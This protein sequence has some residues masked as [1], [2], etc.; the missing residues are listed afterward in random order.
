MSLQTAA[1]RIIG[2]HLG[3]PASVASFQAQASAA[4]RLAG[5]RR[6]A[7]ELRRR[8]QRPKAIV[9]RRPWPAANAR[10]RTLPGRPS[11]P[12]PD[13]YW[14]RNLMYTQAFLLNCVYLEIL[15]RA[16]TRS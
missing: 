3:Y 12:N 5:S 7:A 6:P 11:K 14:L 9:S 1:H 8:E 13:L 15:F 2:S 4:A 16:V 10:H